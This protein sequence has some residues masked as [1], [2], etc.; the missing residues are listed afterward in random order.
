MVVPTVWWFMRAHEM[1][2]QTTCKI[3]QNNPRLLRGNLRRPTI[4]FV[5][6]QI[7]DSSR[8]LR[9]W[10]A[11]MPHPQLWP[12]LRPHSL[13]FVASARECFQRYDCRKA[14][15]FR[16]C[17]RANFLKPAQAAS[18]GPESSAYSCAQQDLQCLPNHNSSLRYLFVLVNVD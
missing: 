4:G 17:S 2:H 10:R 14:G 11:S 8:I 12:H 5:A 15:L 1:H 3:E 13:C 9:D 6:P 18:S 16:L 7:E